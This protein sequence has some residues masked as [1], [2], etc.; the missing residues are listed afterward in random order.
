MAS[1]VKSNT[2]QQDD[3]PPPPM[4]EADINREM[5]KLSKLEPNKINELCNGYLQ[6]V[7]G[8]IDMARRK[9][10]KIADEDEL[11]ELDRLMRLI[12]LAPVEE[13]FIRSKAKIWFAR[14]RILNKDAD[15]FLKKDY[16]AVI[17][18]DQKQVMIETIIRIVQTRYPQ[19]SKAEQDMY[20]EKALEMLQYVAEFKKLTD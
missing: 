18:K 16:S 5:A 20:W 17:K 7:K 3:T 1:S 9:L 4:T 6:R 15:Y 8:L 13:V 11:I 2:N 12:S 19:M 14:H 10:D